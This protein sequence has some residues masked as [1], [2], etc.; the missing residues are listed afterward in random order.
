MHE[1]ELLS[2]GVIHAQL[3]PE[4]VEEIAEAFQKVV[5][6]YRKAAA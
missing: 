4:D 6:H 1:E 2:L 3:S 5:G